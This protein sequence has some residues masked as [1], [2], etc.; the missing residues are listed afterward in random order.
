MLRSYANRPDVIVLGLP[1]GGV[2]VAFEV[3][4][5]LHAPLDVFTVR[6]IA[7]PDNEEYALGA[8]ATG[9][10]VS[11]DWAFAAALRVSDETLRAL[12]ARERSELE[13]REQ[14]YRGDRPLPR[15][16]GR[17]VIVV[18][19]GLA[20]GATMYAAVTALGTLHPARVVVA[21]PIASREAE[22]TLRTVADAVVC[23]CLPV[24][25][26]S[27]GQWYEDFSQTT[28]QEVLRLLSRAARA[29]KPAAREDAAAGAWYA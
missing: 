23:A 8:I 7:V 17:T 2:P 18:D 9:G 1:R 11:V 20:T 29:A 25:L 5:A 12:I 6:K 4:A 27:V 3:A 26:H 13:R 10:V 15:L 16:D 28:D 24:Q 19:D 14:L 21:T 22:A